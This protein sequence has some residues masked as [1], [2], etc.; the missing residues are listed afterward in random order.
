MTEKM[1]DQ[2]GESPAVVH[3]K[4]IENDKVT[5]LD[6]CRSCAEKRGYSVSS[7]EGSDLQNLAH[8]L[9]TMAQDVTGGR[10]AEGIR[11]ASCGLFYTEFTQVG[12][13]GCPDCY[14]AFAAQLE[15]LL[16]KAHGSATHRGRQPQETQSVRE[17]RREIRRLRAEMDRAIRREEFEEAAELRDRIE[18]LETAVRD[19]V[20]REDP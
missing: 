15:P 4:E 13:L 7:A 3:M 6:L 17:E 9:V 19:R 12:R 8:K 18:K 2:C 5:H 14:E 11:C 1:C 16:R 10:D 20:R